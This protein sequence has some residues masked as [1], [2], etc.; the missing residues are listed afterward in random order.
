MPLTDPFN[1]VLH[2]A[3]RMLGFNSIVNPRLGSGVLVRL[4]RPQLWTALAGLVTV[5]LV[6]ALAGALAQ[7]TWQLVT[8]AADPQT[9]LATAP[10]VTVAPTQ[11]P[12]DQLQRIAGLHLFGASSAP[13]KSRQLP[14]DA[15]ETRLKLILK[16]VV[17]RPEPTHG[18][19]VIA[20]PTGRDVLYLPGAE[21]PGAA[22]L[23]QVFDDRVILS[24]DGRYEMLRLPRDAVAMPAKAGAAEAA[25]AAVTPSS[26]T[27]E[28]LAELRQAWQENPSSI[29]E[30]LKIRPV[31][32]N[33]ALHGFAISPR[34]ERDLFDELGLKSGDVV[35][36]IN[37]IA[38]GDTE[39]PEQLLEQ[40]QGASQVTLSIERRGRPQTVELRLNP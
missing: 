9:M 19:A 5:L 1:D 31:R 12:R 16:G 39:S 3:F 29:L 30:E 35:T 11:Q 13:A 28:R 38:L 36:Q 25:G 27:S 33:G 37:G 2:F 20:D 14:I 17:A 7:L 26:G 18:L 10:A 8:P 34:G 6:V 32:R 22:V 4:R 23:E 40:L 24:R 15:P 21:L